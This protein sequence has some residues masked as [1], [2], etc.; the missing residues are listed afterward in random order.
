MITQ[1]PPT[2]LTPDQLQKRQANT[3]LCQKNANYFCKYIQDASGS[4]SPND[5]LTLTTSYCQPAG[6]SLTTTLASTATSVAGLGYFFLAVG[7]LLCAS[8]AANQMM[9]M[10]AIMR[11]FVFL[12]VFG[13]SFVNP[14]FMGGVFLYYV[15]QIFLDIYR[16]SKGIT[17][18]DQFI[19]PATLLPLRLRRPGDGFFTRV[20]LA[21]FTYIDPSPSD[22]GR[23]EYINGAGAYVNRLQHAAGLSNTTL[24]AANM[25]GMKEGIV[26][27]IT[28]VVEAITREGQAR[29]MAAAAANSSKL[30]AAATSTAGVVNR[31]QPATGVSAAPAAANRAQPASGVS[32][33][34]AAANRAQPAANAVSNRSQPAAAPPT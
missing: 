7:A 30:P 15:F 21:P 3:V 27:G 28:S 29:D 23:I 12:V 10:P 8:L 26:K 17:D 25:K 9:Y 11:I 31:A 4:F 34:P 33:A 19:V 20:F 18:R 24:E 6:P 22:P 32:A 5:Y 1:P 2:N 14:F 16:H 13:I